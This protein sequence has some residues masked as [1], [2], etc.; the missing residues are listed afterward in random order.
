MPIDPVFLSEIQLALGSAIMPSLTSA[1]DASDGFEAYLFGLVIRAAQNEG[2]TISFRDVY[3][4]TPATFVF[5]TSPGYISSRERP[6][7]YAIISFPCRPV[8][9]AHLGVRISGRS[10]ILHECDVAVIDQDEAEICRQNRNVH[11]RHGK[12]IMAIEC[13]FFTNRVSLNLVRS[14]VGLISDI[15]KKDR[16]FVVNTPLNPGDTIP[17]YLSTHT[18]GWEHEVVPGSAN[19]LSRLVGAFQNTF[20]NYKARRG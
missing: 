13:K 8:L 14:F 4:T 5:R 12:V 6:Y 15:S 11:P 1:D 2:A 7:T 3:Y 19:A 16:Y 18:Q 10:K 20:K 9:E 17:T